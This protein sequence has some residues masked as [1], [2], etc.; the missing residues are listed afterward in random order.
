MLGYNT[1][2]KA[3]MDCLESALGDDRRE[4]QP[5]QG[6]ARAGARAPA[7]SRGPSCTACERRG[8]KTT[9]A[10]RTRSRAQHLA[11]AFG[12]RAVDW[13]ARHNA[14]VDIIVNCTPVGMHP[15]VDETPFNKIVPQAVD[16][17]VRHGLQSGVDAA[18]QG[19]Q[20]ARLP[21]R[22]RR[23]D[24]HPPGGAAV[25]CCS[26][27]RKRPT[28][29][30]RET[31]KRAIG[32]VKYCVR[33]SSGVRC[34]S[35][36]ITQHGQC[37][38]AIFS[39]RLS[40][41]GQD[42]RRPARWPRGSAATGSMPTTRSNAAPASR[43]PRSLPTTAK[44][45]FAIWKRESSPTCA[46]ATRTVVALGGGA[47]LREENRAAIASCRAGRLADGVGR[48]DRSADRRRRGDRRAAGPT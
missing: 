30:M 14:D 22:D 28:Q 29:L 37:D 24:V 13:Q 12:G 23:R 25:L 9:I 3:A 26:P 10:G 48:H 21:H 40:R 15:N 8:A 2:Y 4:P 27:A 45:R 39:D 6:Q 11:D 33:A 18:V 43:S 46:A 1:D 16:D 34:G 20:V 31:L 35:V 17:R 36:E 42:D 5:A 47:V 32:P 44:R 38:H 19:S 7:A 41:H